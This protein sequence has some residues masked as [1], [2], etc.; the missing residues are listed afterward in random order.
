VPASQSQLSPRAAVYVGLLVIAAGAAPILGALGVLPLRL[1]RGTPVW[2][3]VCAGLLFVL[4]GLAVING[5]A[6]GGL[7]SG[8]TEDP[9]NAGHGDY[10][11]RDWIQLILGIGICG[12]LAAIAGWVAF[13]PGDR[14]FSTSI[15]LPFLTV[16]GIGGQWMGRAAFGLGAIAAAALGVAFAA[17]AIRRTKP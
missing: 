15:S 14:Q 8:S 13:G 7:P 11:G 12:M 10:T 5:S 17:R 2:V 6:F 1:T 4:G 3:G 16:R 9:A